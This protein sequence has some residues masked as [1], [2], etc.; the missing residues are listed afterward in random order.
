MTKR[1][2]REWLCAPYLITPH[3]HPQSTHDRNPLPP[4]LLSISI[5]LNHDS[6]APCCAT[7]SVSWLSHDSVLAQCFLMVTIMRRLV[8]DVLALTKLRFRPW[9]MTSQLSKGG[10]SWQL[11][12]HRQ[13]FVRY[14]ACALQHLLCWIIGVIPH[15]SLLPPPTYLTQLLT[16]RCRK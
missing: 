13:W 5:Q 3:H 6:P 9:E 7:S 1:Y 2:P 4:A 12:L 16:L 11:S 15:V 10:A 14:V 8:S